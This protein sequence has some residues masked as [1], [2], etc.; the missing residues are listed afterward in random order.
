MVED[1]VQT[2]KDQPTTLY[3]DQKK[4]YGRVLGQLELTDS[5]DPDPAVLKHETISSKLARTGSNNLF[6]VNYLD[7]EF[8]K[9]QANHG[10]E[11]V[12]FSRDVNNA[13]ERMTVYA[14][15]HNFFKKWR[16]NAR[17]NHTHAEVAG[18]SK[19]TIKRL[20][21]TLFTRRYFFSKVSFHSSDWRLWL[22]L[23]ITPG[24]GM[25]IPKAQYSRAG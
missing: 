6:S 25:G 13:M 22:R 11:T 19:K 18:Y 1:L 8:R 23:Y 14:G 3:S 4:E 20:L 24:Q 5:P 9:D 10:R 7:R 21:K 16:I 2:R 12:Q 15:Y 17:E